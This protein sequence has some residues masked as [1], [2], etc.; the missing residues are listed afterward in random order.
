L[1]AVEYLDKAIKYKD[2]EERLSREAQ[3]ALK[4]A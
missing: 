4:K 1:S 3:E 2:E